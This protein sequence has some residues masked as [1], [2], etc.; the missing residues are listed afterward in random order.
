MRSCSLDRLR[1]IPAR[2]CKADHA[3]DDILHTLQQRVIALLLLPCLELAQ[4]S[5]RWLRSMTSTYRGLGHQ[6]GAKIH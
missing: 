1:L 6:V 4:I 2:S 3:E 5:F